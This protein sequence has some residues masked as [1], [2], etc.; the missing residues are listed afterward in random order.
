MTLEGPPFRPL[1]AG[2]APRVLGAPPQRRLGAIGT[3]SLALAVLEVLYCIQV[4]TTAAL[5]GPILDLHRKVI[6]S[7]LFSGA[8]VRGAIA[9]SS[10]AARDFAAIISSWELV[11]ALLLGAAA[12]SLLIIALRLRRGERGALSTTR[13][14]ALGSLGVMG[15]SALIQLIRTIPAISSY[16][17][18]LMTL[19]REATRGASSPLLDVPR[20]MD[21]SI[22]AAIGLSLFVGIALFAVGPLVLGVWADRLLRDTPLNVE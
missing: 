13:A 17:R 18:Q 4:I 12:A 7:R 11:R 19:A 22:T 15:S 6:G 10:A 20:L 16:Q 1:L 8:A 21:V 14:W 2:D 5:L 3:A 9:A